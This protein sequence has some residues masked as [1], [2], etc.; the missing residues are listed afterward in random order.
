MVLA[1]VLHN[2]ANECYSYDTNI[3]NLKP[4]SCHNAKASHK[5]IS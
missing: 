3:S 2:F 5:C 4:N 1:D